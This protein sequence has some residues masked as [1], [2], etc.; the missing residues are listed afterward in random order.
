MLRFSKPSTRRLTKA[1]TFALGGLAATGL[2]VLA[3]TIGASSASAATPG[4]N[5]D[6]WIKQSLAV[7][8]A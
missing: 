7:M 1:R 4:G 3:A 6:G 2:S 5:V 8:H